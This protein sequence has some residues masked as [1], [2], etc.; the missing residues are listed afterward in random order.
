[1]LSRPSKRCA[2]FLLLLFSMNA[3]TEE[4]ASPAQ[5]TESTTCHFYQFI[6]GTDKQSDPANQVTAFILNNWIELENDL[7]RGQGDVLTY[8]GELA[9]CPYILPAGLW[10]T[11]LN[12][13]PYEQRAEIFKEIFFEQC[14]CKR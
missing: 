6:K 3:S 9:L 10:Q 14:F 4:S 1:M 5:N 11:Q 12:G 13:K 7:A 2:L 8:L